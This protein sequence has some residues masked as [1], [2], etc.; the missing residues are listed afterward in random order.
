MACHYPIKGALISVRSRSSK[1][2]SLIS[3]CNQHVLVRFSIGTANQRFIGRQV[4]SCGSSDAFWL[5]P[6]PRLSSRC[7][8]RFGD[9]VHFVPY[10]VLPQY[11]PEALSFSRRS[12]LGCSIPAP[13][14]HFG[15]C[16]TNGIITDK[17]SV[18]SASCYWPASC[19]VSDAAPLP[20]PAF[21][22]SQGNFCIT[23][24]H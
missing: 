4:A 8:T 10:S 23:L 14:G 20:V 22:S 21:G 15:F 3:A 2:L 7:I 24:D 13:V 9:S 17:K 5:A 12:T 6:K 16:T 11:A 18:N 19:S 1:G